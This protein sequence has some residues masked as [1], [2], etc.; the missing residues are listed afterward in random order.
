MYIVPLEKHLQNVT[1]I[2]E[3]ALA[4]KLKSMQRI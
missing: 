1:Q 4:E 2:S 3:D